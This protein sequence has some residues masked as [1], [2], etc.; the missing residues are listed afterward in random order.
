M[1][2]ESGKQSV[3]LANVPK[4]EIVSFLFVAGCR[5]AEHVAPFDAKIPFISVTGNRSRPGDRNNAWWCDFRSRGAMAMPLQHRT[6]PPFCQSDIA[7]SRTSKS[8]HH[9]AELFYCVGI[10][11]DPR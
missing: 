9:F 6:C 3:V 7:T 11:L 1:L 5:L 4:T 2:S 10:D 8:P